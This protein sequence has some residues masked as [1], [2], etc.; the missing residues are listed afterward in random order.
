MNNESMANMAW[1]QGR[2]HNYRAALEGT[3]KTSRNNSFFGHLG[4]SNKMIKYEKLFRKGF[5][6]K[7]SWPVQY[8][9]R[10]LHT[11]PNNVSNKMSY[12][13]WTTVKK[14][15]ENF[16]TGV[17]N[18]SILRLNTK[19]L[20]NVPVKTFNTGEAEVVLPPMKFILNRNSI[21]RTSMK[22]PVIPVSNIVINARFS[23]G[24][25]TKTFIPRTAA[26][27]MP[28]KTAMGRLRAFLR[29]RK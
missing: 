15:A 21:N 25:N 10:G 16:G 13:S 5:R 28:P 4:N 7:N 22:A 24:P 17:G 27:R 29:R 14:V 2:H 1:I 26:I 9:Y 23:A 3:I 20:K 6:V 8:I 12:S 11:K 18:G 19:L